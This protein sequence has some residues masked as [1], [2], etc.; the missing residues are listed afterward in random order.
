MSALADKLATGRRAGC[1]NR[2]KQKKLQL[3]KKGVAIRF[4]L[5]HTVVVTGRDRP[6]AQIGER[7]PGIADAEA[8][9]RM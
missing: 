6:H 8:G 4:G 1:L 3:A 7:Q 9:S 5:V 2:P